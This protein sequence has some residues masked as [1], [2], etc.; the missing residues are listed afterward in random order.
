MTYLNILISGSNGFIGKNLVQSLKY[1]Y[2]IFRY[3][4]LLHNSSDSTII[5]KLEKADYLIHLAGVNRPANL[6]D[7]KDNYRFT[8]KI[9]DFL[10]LKKKKIANYFFFYC[11]YWKK[12]LK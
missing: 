10:I 3:D 7:F 4:I 2:K 8:K 1:Q 9:C 5:K 11:A 12:I 6:K